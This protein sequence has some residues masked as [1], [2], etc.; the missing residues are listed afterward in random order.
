[1]NN[2]K[3]LKLHNQAK[4]PTRSYDHAVAFDLFPV[5][6]GHL[7]PTVHSFVPLGFAAEFDPGYGAFIFDRSGMGAKGVTRFAGVIDPDYRGEWKVILFNSTNETLYYTTEKAIAQVVF[8]KVELPTW[9]EVQELSPSLRDTK[10]WGSTDQPPVGR[11]IDVGMG[12][13]S[14]GGYN[15]KPNPTSEPKPYNP[16]PFQPKGW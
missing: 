1:M 8:L 7:L 2:I 14:R 9:E 15:E 4:L 11:I 5:Q 10:G 6:D 13:S 12:F 16:E 3:F